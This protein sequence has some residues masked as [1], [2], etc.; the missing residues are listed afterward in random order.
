MWIIEKIFRRRAKG[1]IRPIK[2]RYDRMIVFEGYCGTGDK[3]FT[4]ERTPLQPLIFHAFG[5]ALDAIEREIWVQDDAKTRFDRHGFYRA[6]LN[7]EGTYCWFNG[8]EAL[9]R[10]PESNHEGEDEAS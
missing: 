8:H 10:D 2:V 6:H 4:K 5:F 9:V 7:A 1:Y 3:L